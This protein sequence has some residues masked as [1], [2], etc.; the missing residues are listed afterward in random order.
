[1]SKSSRRTIFLFALVGFAFGLVGCGE[2]AAQRKAFIQ[3][4]QT[5]I[6][7]KPGLHIP[8]MSDQDI[9]NFGPYADQY[10]IMNG[11]HHRLGASITQDLARAMQVGSPRSLAELANHRDILPVLKAGMANMK[12]ELEAAEAEAD[13]AHKALQQPPDLKAVYDAAYEHMVTK[14]AAIFRELIPLMQNAL[15]AIEDLAAFLDEYRNAIDFRDNT[16]VS[17]NSY[18]QT[19]LATLMEAATKSA[20]V[21][22]AARRKLRAMVEGN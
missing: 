9:T 14:P 18:V 22:D 12:S 6:I 2:E 4:L 21:S 3:F 17:T 20:A 8:I 16:P 10:R 11:F 15:P 7:D 19:K 13:A 5:R 1:M